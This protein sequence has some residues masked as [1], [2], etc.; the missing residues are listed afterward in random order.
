MKINKLL[1]EPFIQVDSSSTRSFGGTGLGLSICRR[2]A[3]ALG[4][5]VSVDSQP[6]HGSTFTLRIRIPTTGELIRPN[7]TLSRTS[8]E[9]LQEIPLSCTVLIVDDRRDIRYLAQHFIERAGGTVYT[10]T[11]GKEA[12]KFIGDADS[13]RIEIIVLDMQMPVMDGYEA[14]TELRRLGCKL[15]IIALTA[16]AM[17][18]DRDECLA[19]GCTDY[20]TKLLDRQT[21]VAMIHRL[22]SAGL[23]GN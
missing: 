20:T 3:R 22:T 13:P 5:D 17:R 9:A 23:A 19:A 15:P 7:L 10:A 14:A 4:G 8:E 21:L 16:N 6:G 18:S 12:V 1:F 11:N 2:L